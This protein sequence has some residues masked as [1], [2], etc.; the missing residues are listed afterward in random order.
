[1]T[2]ALKHSMHM[3]QVFKIFNLL[4]NKIF[5]FQLHDSKK[6]ITHY[7]LNKVFQI[8]SILKFRSL[9]LHT[10][11]IVTKIN[12]GFL[13]KKERV[14]RFFVFMTMLSFKQF[15]SNCS[16]KE[17]CTHCLNFEYHNYGITIFSICTQNGCTC[18]T[19]KK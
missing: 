15:E 4:P 18:C 14:K 7:K 12:K 11:I 2:G 8:G 3:T 19:H 13:K 10:I 5:S 17:P 9:H 1:M 16:K 6:N